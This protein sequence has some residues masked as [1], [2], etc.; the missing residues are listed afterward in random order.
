[1]KDDVERGQ[2]YI[3]EVAGTSRQ[4]RQNGNAKFFVGAIG[5][6][7]SASVLAE[8]KARGQRQQCSSEGTELHIHLRLT[9]N[10]RSFRYFLS[11]LCETLHAG[12]NGRQKPRR[13][14]RFARLLK[15]IG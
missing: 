5:A 15:R 10:S 1:M 2:Q 14:P 3:I 8:S 11:K 9:N 6:P 4:M 13:L 12:P 7:A